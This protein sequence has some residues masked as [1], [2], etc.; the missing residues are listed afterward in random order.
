MDRWQATRTHDEL[1]QHAE[2]L[3]GLARALVGDAVVADDLAQDAWLA[4]GARSLD[5]SSTRPFLARVVRRLASKWR[6]GEGRRVARERDASRDEHVPS[7]DESLER[8]ETQELLVRALKGLP[9][10]YRGTLMLRYFDGL[11]AAEIARRT[12]VPAGTVRSRI[13]RGLEELRARLDAHACGDRSSWMLALLPIASPPHVA[14]GVGATSVGVISAMGTKWI[15]VSAALLLAALLVWQISG[16]SSRP[17][18]VAMV[19]AREP[20][21]AL[22]P[23][24]GPTLAADGDAQRVAIPSARETD[25]PARANSAAARRQRTIK[26]RFVDFG[27]SP[28]AGATLEVVDAV[29]G[30]NALSRGDGRVELRFDAPV[31]VDDKLALRV[32]CEGWVSKDLTTPIDDGETIWLGDVELGR[33]GTI[34]GRVV[35]EARVG[36]AGARVFAQEIGHPG[37]NWIEAGPLRDTLE[38][39][40]TAA[41]DR[42]GAFELKGIPEGYWTLWAHGTSHA[43]TQKSF[44]GVAQGHATAIE[45]MVSELDEPRMLCGRVVDPNGAPVAGAS[46]ALF[47]GNGRT[48][49]EVQRVTRG[50]GSFEIEIG[51]RSDSLAALEVSDARGRWT[52]IRRTE[53][54]A[55]TLEL[56]LAFAATR[57]LRLRATGPDDEALLGAEVFAFGADRVVINDC[58][59]KCDARGGASFRMPAQPFSLSICAGGYAR[60]I[61]G[62]FDPSQVRDEI[63]ARL[64]RGPGLRGRVEAAGRG[65][66]GARVSL[67]RAA[68]TGMHFQSPNRA[69]DVVPFR[70]L[71]V[72]EPELVV[73]TSSDG[74]FAMLPPREQG[75]WYLVVD[76]REHAAAM[77]GPLDLGPQSDA[78]ALD[79]HLTAGGAI[80]GFVRSSHYGETEGWTV[81]ADNA[82][83]SRRNGSVA[84]DGSYRIEHLAPGDWQVRACL[85]DQDPRLGTPVRQSADAIAWDTLVR[86]GETTRF[87]VE[88]QGSE[89]YVLDAELAVRSGLP[90]LWLGEVAEL[91]SEMVIR[92]EG[93]LVTI[94]GHFQSRVSAPGAIRITL[95]SSD[96]RWQHAEIVDTVQ[97]DQPRT[98]WSCE[99]ALAHVSGRSAT[100][101]DA[102]VDCVCNQSS[103]R[104]IATRFHVDADGKFDA[105]VPA[106][107]VKFQRRPELDAGAGAELL[108]LSLAEGADQQLSLP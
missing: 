11:D 57:A 71:L 17:A 42:S 68:P 16:N 44:V 79:L 56:V 3:R 4:F 32:T 2:W 5:E 89:K 96:P 60:K 20:T 54:R 101:R 78:G 7:P 48:W 6:R 46:V 34:V 100:L 74:V 67:H 33:A 52:P 88:V 40:F 73:S 105:S 59:A 75:R 13:T 47:D 90:G 37:S 19:E 29:R 55:S 25:P 21:P 35:D 24:D 10:P 8:L 86:E 51:P 87:D 41:C 66:E 94:D 53:V 81:Y 27:G 1:A 62:P 12:G 104:R 22:A 98:R 26:A 38:S 93:R 72:E 58:V 65:V 23:Q 92:E 36:V 18:S 64:E 108:V 80:E 106:G 45:L 99:F 63:T 82:L 76:G 95:T 107:L 30:P 39:P 43:W 49:F 85:R 70:E 31:E 15:V 103:T 83:G 69:G 77:L 97:I 9:E 91:V 61:L 102:D 14:A 84:P 28:I 50:D